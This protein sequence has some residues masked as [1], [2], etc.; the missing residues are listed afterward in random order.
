[1]EIVTYVIILLITLV[2]K[3]RTD[4][5]ELIKVS[6]MMTYKI[7]FCTKNLT[8][9]FIVQV[10][11]IFVTVIPAAVENRY[12]SFPFSIYLYSCRSSRG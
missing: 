4:E 3:S 6:Y 7:D 11:I 1:M 8:W 9:R 2:F 5:K 12:F 10:T